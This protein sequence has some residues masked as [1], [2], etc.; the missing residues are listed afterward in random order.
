MPWNENSST[1]YGIILLMKLNLLVKNLFAVFFP[2]VWLIDVNEI[3]YYCV[4]LPSYKP[5][6]V[7]LVRLSFL[8]DFN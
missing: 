4:N 2:L 7:N 6:M 5:S 1:G 3:A 8:M